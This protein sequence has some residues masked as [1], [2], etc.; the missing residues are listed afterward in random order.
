MTDG[1]TYEEEELSPD[2][3]AALTLDRA[4]TWAI[5]GTIVV[6]IL[7]VAAVWGDMHRMAELMAGFSAA[8]FIGLC[9]WTLAERNDAP[10]AAASTCSWRAP[11]RS[12][13]Q[14]SGWAWPC[15]G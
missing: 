4:H 1:M 14:R 2:L 13:G 5:N 15:S 11:G 3:H 10:D 6:Q 7:L 9:A 8:A 12:G